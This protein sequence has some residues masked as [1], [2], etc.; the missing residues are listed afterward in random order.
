MSTAM[1]KNERGWLTPEGERLIATAL[2]TKTPREVAKAFGVSDQTVYRVRDKL[3]QTVDVQPE[4]AT[5][6]PSADDAP[7]DDEQQ[8][9]IDAQGARIA[10]LETHVSDL[11][12]ECFRLRRALEARE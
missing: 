2:R 7:A 12:M 3:A 5:P 9:L 1:M 11:S 10:E 8:A 6:P 4:P